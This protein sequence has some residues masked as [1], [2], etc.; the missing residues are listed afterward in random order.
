MTTDNK[1]FKRIK[2]FVFAFILLIG[3]S[4]AVHA[5]SKKKNTK[6]ATASRNT[7]AS[8][9]TIGDL[10]TKA[11]RGAGANLGEK[12]K[13]ALPKAQTN[14]GTPKRP[15]NLSAVKPPR[16]STFFEDDKS[17]KAELE[18][19]TDQQINELFKLTQ[20][21]K[22]SKQRGELWLRLAELYVEKAAIIDFRKQG[23]Y[24]QKLKDYQA[25]VT[26]KKPYLDL[27]DAM[28]YNRKAIQLYEWFVR[29]F[30]RDLKVDQALFF[31]GYNYYEIN[32]VKKGTQYYTRLTKQFP[33]SPYIIETNFALAEYYF[34]NEKW[35]EA[36]SY[37][38]KI[39]RYKKHRLYFF[40]LYKYAWSDFRLGNT[41]QALRSMEVLVRQ[42]RRQTE[43]ASLDGLKSVNKSR[44]E[45]E[46]LRDI[47]LFYSEI[48]SPDQA[49]SYFNRLAGEQGDDF[50]EKLA[51]LYGD[52][53]NLEG[54][55]VLFN[56]LISRRSTNPKAFD[57][58]YQIVKLYGT[59]KKS[60]EFREEIYSWIKD[61]SRSSAWGRANSSNTALLEESYKLRETTLRNYVLQQHQTAQNS[62]APFSQG[63]ALEGYRIYITE[64]SD[65]P[66]IGDM[67]FYFGELLY[68]MKKY[69]DAGVQY[70]WVIE[71]AKSSKFYQR[72]AENIIIALEKDLPSDKEIEQRV[73]DT[74]DPVEMDDKSKRF[75]STGLWYLGAFP[76]S[77]KNPEVK[78]RIG[79]LFYMHN[80][81]EKAVPH[82]REIVQ[83]YPK[84]KYAEYSANLLLDVFNI[85]KDLEG[86]EK[87][88]QELLALP[89]FANSK[90]AGDI[91]NVL[92]RASFKKAQDLEVAKNYGES[93]QQFEIFAA[94][95]PGSSLV[96]NAFFNAAINFERAGMNQKAI[97]NHEKILSNRS[98][99][100]SKLQ[101]QSRRILPKL[102]QD[103]GRLAE[104]AAAYEAAA[105]EAGK[106]KAAAN[107]FFNAAVL[108]EALGNKIRAV[109]NYENFYNKTRGAERAEALFSMAKIQVTRNQLT[110]ASENFK[111]YVVESRNQPE[112]TVEASYYVYD[113]SKRLR[114]T[115][116]AEEWKRKTLGFQA[117]YAPEKRGIGAVYAAKIKLEEAEQVF[118]EFKSIRIPSNPAQ[119]QQAAQKKIGLVSRLTKELAEVI[120]F[121]T[122]NEIVASLSILG[123]TNLHMA[124]ALLNSPIPA[125]LTAEQ[126]T[127]Y[128]DGIK[129]LADPFMEKAKEGLKAAIDRAS[130]L[131]AF[132]SHYLT[133]RELYSKIDSSVY[134]GSEQPLLSRQGEWYGL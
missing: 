30:P 68:D 111:K 48:G 53:G 117:R 72:A 100:A 85:K 87:V 46:G 60:R 32:N 110:L 104:A 21:F 50:V 84:T 2:Y 103:S 66:L 81:F 6:K 74:L 89:A 94:Q 56:Y 9:K 7:K 122:P 90:A 37:Y 31:L 38:G 120:Q 63:L 78:F 18:R 62:R 108:F 70:R 54:A 17:D 1:K 15:V 22:N 73:G 96:V 128:K 20:R 33:R 29:D 118:R 64:F 45:S 57:Y 27:R 127:Q 121:D 134:F 102:Y 83:K 115:A 123:Q 91:K 97:Q 10:L 114:K 77:E 131:D 8:K 3:F 76:N 16:S 55:R 82:F 47:V 126:A 23:E 106:D 105:V 86:L 69:E 41:K 13:I 119:Q 79:R 125:G 35:R 61:F 5:Q 107:L 92:E 19:I 36:K 80:E 93:A 51:Y 116:Q 12:S 132:N 25:G 43:Q 75:V 71:N 11:D 124:E 34:E 52:K 59:A 42:G 67:R 129:K 133:A 98:K 130:E 4:S 65:S 44:L 88:A 95:N 99:E 109:N 113:L 26:K 28:E 49:P 101:P 58:K 39:L 40:S 24:D 14:F 112:K